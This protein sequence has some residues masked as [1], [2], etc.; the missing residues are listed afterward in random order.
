M[1]SEH[2]LPINFAGR[3]GFYWWIGQIEFSDKVIK[4]S[5]RFKVRIVGQHLKDCNA[6][7]TEDLPWATVMLPATTPY[8]T[9]NT[10]GATA[11]FKP[12]DWVIGFFLDGMEG[13]QP[14]IM[15]SIG[16][17]ANA[18]NTTPE[19]DPT[20]NETCKA[21]TTFVRN[22]YVEATDKQ[23]GGKGD[24][25]DKINKNK[26]GTVGAG[27]NSTAPNTLLALPCENSTNNP[28]G[29]EFCVKLAKPTC[30]ADTASQFE[31]ILGDLFKTISD[32]NGK[33][34]SAL[35]SKYTGGMMNVLSEAQGYINKCFAVVR[36]L[37]SRVKGEIIKWIRKGIDELLKAI[38]TPKNGGL[39]KVIEYMKKQLEKIGCTIDG[40]LERIFDFLTNLIFGLIMN[41]LNSATCAVEAALSSLLN[42]LQSQINAAIASI[43]SG[44]QSILSVIASPLDVIGSAI[45]YVMDLLGISCSGIEDSCPGEDESCTTDKPKKGNALDNLLA[46]LSEGALADLATFCPD[47]YS[48]GGTAPT[49]ASVIGGI[50]TTPPASP[51]PPAGGGALASSSTPTPT[52]TLTASAAVANE[53]DTIT[54][55]VTATNVPDGTDLPYAFSCAASEINV[56]IS[57]FI[58]V[59]LPTPAS[60]SV[61]GTLTMTI[62]DDAV[63][64]FADTITL[65]LFDVAYNI[66][67]SETIA[68]NES[69]TPVIP[70]IITPVN[71]IINSTA[72]IILTNSG[73]TASPVAFIPF[74][75]AIPPVP[76]A[77]VVSTISVSVSS[78][79]NFDILNVASPIFTTLI[80]PVV[81]TPVT[82]YALTADKV[83]VREGESITFTFNTT[84]V[85]DYTIFNY[86]MFGPEISSSDFVSGT[87]TGSFEVIGNSATIQ[88]DIAVDTDI[89]GS[90]ICEFAVNGTG[91]SRTFVILP[92]VIVSPTPTTTPPTPTFVT[93]VPCPPVVDASGAIVS[94]SICTVGGPYKTP[95]AISISGA[96]FGASAVA[97][98]D[99]SGYLTDITI[100]RSGTGYE[101]TNF[102]TQCIITGFIMTRVG[103]S[104][105][106]A[107]TVYVDGDSTVATATIDDTGRVVS[108]DIIDRTRVF[109]SYPQVQIFGDGYGAAA[110]P[111]VSCLAP[112]EIVELGIE[113]AGGDREGS[114]VDCP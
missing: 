65:D 73:S 13:Q 30:D 26:G 100:L 91:Q 57:G 92:D 15:G 56:P 45:K 21:F 11:N 107:P 95:P 55:T 33:L 101:P 112:E 74:V 9:G 114:Y 25:E 102:D 6:V 111:K 19:N 94:V 52:Y 106:T 12:G 86:T 50:T 88:I 5:N 46:A 48:G 67:A 10:S 60:T 28:F 18:S 22:D 75:P 76:P 44:I 43:L 69:D 80:T 17:V 70:P 59:T 99:D 87:T 84:N 108:V 53:G 37:L 104:Y 66:Q 93:P 1:L 27:S 62:I 54:Y 79:L 78:T 36:T 20:P 2:N 83:F 72:N 14:V 109:E 71:A 23:K 41:I 63:F 29:T 3:D 85:P 81:P 90:Q 32:S 105:T 68:V 8:S 49:V 39:K 61:T 4:P 77:P 96:G 103:S 51:P 64:E 7:A 97:N 34:G 24:A 38:L 31:S 42:N 47:A 98:L 110:V 113:L 58:N 35:I 16:A 89:E 82:S 40:L